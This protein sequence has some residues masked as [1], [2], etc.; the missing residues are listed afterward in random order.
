MGL[1]RAFP[2]D[3][4]VIHTIPFVKLTRM[5]LRRDKSDFQPLAAL[6]VKDPMDLR[7]LLAAG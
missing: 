5:R 4:V 1:F 7:P 3:S 2:W 6:V